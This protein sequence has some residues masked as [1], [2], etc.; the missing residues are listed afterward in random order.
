M[1]QLI[2]DATITG[3]LDIT[4][5]TGESSVTVELENIW[6]SKSVD[7]AVW[8]EGLLTYTINV[9]NDGDLVTPPGPDFTDVVIQD[10]IDV[11]IAEFLME[12]ITFTPIGSGTVTSYVPET[13][14]LTLS[15]QDI[16]VGDTVTITFQVARALV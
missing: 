4:Q 2:N 13:G 10:T 15:L 6:F 11:N 9:R 1:P 3:M 8:T 16:A 14:V 12:T 7:K 5:V